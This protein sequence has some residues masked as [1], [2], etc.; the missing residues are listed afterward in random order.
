MP[1]ENFSYSHMP[2]VFHGDFSTLSGFLRLPHQDK[3]GTIM[4][5]AFKNREICGSC[6]KGRVR[7]NSLSPGHKLSA[8]LEDYI[9]FLEKEVQIP[10]KYVG[11]GPDRDQIIEL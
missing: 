1:D 9:R 10:V 5:G 8:G 3:F 4:G 11:V 2:S 7:R 6:C